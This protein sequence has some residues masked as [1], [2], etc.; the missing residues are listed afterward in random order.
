MAECV[1]MKTVRSEVA[2]AAIAVSVCVAD[3]GAAFISTR[4]SSNT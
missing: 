3:D 1:A 2:A 4:G